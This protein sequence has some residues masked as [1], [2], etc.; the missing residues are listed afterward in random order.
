M[1]QTMK[2]LVKTERKAGL[3][4]QQRDV[5]HLGPYDVLIKVR[6]TSICGTDLHI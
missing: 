3:T 6:A 5:P 4:L 1:N 2:A